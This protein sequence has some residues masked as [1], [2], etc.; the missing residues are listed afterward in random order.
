VTPYTVPEVLRGQPPDAPSDFSFGAVLYGLLTGRRAFE[1][2]N[3]DALRQRSITRRQRRRAAPAV[4]RLVASCLAKEPAAR[5]QRL[6]KIILELKLLTVAV[7]R[8]DTPCA[9]AMKPKPPCARRSSSSRPALPRGWRR[10]IRAILE[11]RGAVSEAL[12]SLRDPLSA[13][14]AELAAAQERAAQVGRSVEET[15]KT[16]SAAIESV[17]A[18][19][20]QTD[21]LVERVMEALVSLQTTA[22]KHS[23]EG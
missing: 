18:A 5:C 20:A 23:G 19:T 17:R 14:R 11:F 22:F 10:T 13:V 7:Q 6:Q 3:P 15:L 8:A 12:N 9:A 1:G 16:P 4:D 21:D 2:D